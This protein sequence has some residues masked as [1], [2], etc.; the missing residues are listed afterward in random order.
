[1]N[2][3]LFIILLLPVVLAGV[4]LIPRVRFNGEVG[5]EH[6]LVR[7]YN[8][9]FRA[10]MDFQK[11]KSFLKIL[12]FRIRLSRE[13]DE[14]PEEQS[15]S[16]HPYN[17]ETDEA[18]SETVSE[19]I[20]EEPI[21]STDKPLIDDIPPSTKETEPTYRKPVKQRKLK[22]Q[23]KPKEEKTKSDERSIPW[24]LFWQEWD[25]LWLIIKKMANSMRRL[26][27]TPHLDLIKVRLFIASPD[28]ALT[29]VIYSAASQFKVFEKPPQ[30]QLI[31]NSDFSSEIPHGE[32][33]LAVS[34]RPIIVIFESLYMALRLPWL[35]IYIVYRKWKK[36]GKEKDKE[37]V[38]VSAE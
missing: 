20:F 23:R 26:L 11:K 15:N 14:F 8:I 32:L 7:I 27:K 35:R 30:R 31:I 2:A 16:K 17:L 25:L 36:T 10:E 29:G 1:V 13:E 21:E 12:F 4:I 6:K 33:K 28:P 24:S 18:V 19:G 37:A 34:I 5:S 38:N 3:L 9:W 22:F